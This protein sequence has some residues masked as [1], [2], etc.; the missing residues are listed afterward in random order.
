V[1]A[2]GSGVAPT[3]TLTL[4]VGSSQ[5]GNTGTLSSGSFTFTNAQLPASLNAAASAQTLVVTYSG[6]GN[7]N[8]TTL[9]LSLTVNKANPSGTL[10]SNGATPPT[11]TVA[12]SA[13]AGNVGIPGGTANFY[14]DGGLLNATPVTLTSGVA[15]Y[16][17]SLLSGTHT[18]TATYSGDTNFNA[19]ASP[20]NLTA[21][22]PAAATTT[23]VIASSTN[24]TV[25][26]TVTYTV[27]VTGGES[28]PQGT[29]Q[30]SDNGNAIC[31]GAPITVP[32][33]SQTC[34]VTYT[35]SGNYAAGTHTITAAYTSTDTTRW[36]NS[37][38]TSTPVTVTVA[39]RT[40][41][42]GT[43][44]SSQGASY[45][46]GTATIL[47]VTLT[48]GNPAPAYTGTVQFLDSGSAL[49]G[50]VTLTSTGTTTTATLSGVSL[51]VGSHS[52]TAQF[53]ADANYSASSASSALAIN[54]GKASSNPTTA[55]AS[56]TATYGGTLTTSAISVPAAGSGVAPTGTLTLSVGS[57]QIGNPGTLSSGSFTFTNAQLPASLNAAASAQ[58]LLV[59]YGGD[60]NYNSTTL[61]LSLTVNKANP[62]GTL[63]SN[64]ASPPTF[65]LALS[66]PGASVGIPSGTAN[67]YVDGTKQNATPVPVSA[68]GVA[69]YALASS[70]SGGS[71]TITATYS[72]DTNFNAPASPF[73]L[74]AALPAAATTTTV[75]ASTTDPAV[76]FRVTYTVSVTGG[77]SAP[78]GTVQVSDNGNAICVG[79]PLSVPSGSQTCTVTYDGS[80]NHTAGTHTITAA[81]TST[82]TTRWLNSD[83]TST[84]V[85]VTVAKINV[86]LGAIVSS[87]G[88][89]YASGTATNLTVTLTP[90]NPSP[91][92]T[93]T[94]QFLDGGSPLSGTVT[95]TSTGTTTTA[96]LSG[97]SL[98]VGSHSITAQFGADPNYNSSS[99]TALAITVTGVVLPCQY[100]LTPPSAS[101]PSGGGEGGFN[102]TTGSACSWTAVVS[103]PSWITIT[104]VSSGSGVQALTYTT[105]LNTTGSVRNGTITVN[106]IVYSIQQFSSACSFSINPSSLTVSPAGGSASLA[107]SASGPSCQWTASGLGATPASGTGSGEIVIAIPASTSAAQQTLTATIGGQT[108]TVTQAGTACTAALNSSGASFPAAG[109]TGSVNVTTPSAC[110]Y[111]TVLGPDWIS[112]TAGGSG[113]GSGTLAYSVAPNAVT[114]SRSGAL[115]IGGQT[116]QITQQAASCTV[117]VDT[118]TS[119]F[120]HEFG[121][122]GGTGNISI[123]T[124]GPNC[125]W[126]ATSP[127]AWATVA[128]ASGTGNGSVTVTVAANQATSA[129][130]T[131]LSIGGQTVNVYEEGTSCSYGLQSA[132]ASVPAS[133]GTS[134]VGVIA[135]TGCSWTASANASWLSIV[136]SGSAGTA[137]V[138][139]SAQANTTS[140]ARSGTLTIAGL[141]YTV[142]QAGAACVFNLSATGA[143]VPSG[144]ISNSF[145]VSTPTAGCLVA[146]VPDVNWITVTA[147]N[148]ASGTVAY[149][150]AANP[151]AGSRTG[152]IRVGNASFAISQQG[153]ACGFTLTSYSAAF[154]YLGGSGTITG[155]P[156]VAGCTPAVSAG[157]TQMIALGTLSGPV[158]QTFTLPF[159]VSAFSSNTPT[160]RT[161]SISF[162]GQSFLVKQSSY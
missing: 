45:A 46:Y 152:N 30:V 132:S 14:S 51:G 28:A 120:S 31:V 122:A 79:A 49:P 59:T 128:P 22:L 26:N 155:T 119:G 162:G 109:G 43:I 96:T 18:I 75:T 82:D 135:G 107:V 19:P 131:G 37:N 98:G 11:F 84:P 118:N 38:S 115:S 133:G 23:T 91:A 9:S 65:T 90:G 2:A 121:N 61:S 103:D 20:F 13:P 95:L 139:W 44:M 32:S 68:A 129:L 146:A 89:S 58:A 80:T 150:V 50:T 130:S 4:T 73:N 69:T 156:N 10:T 55:T 56:Y 53:G 161:A 113:V 83:S 97:V 66:A 157:N 57:S 147:V 106:G 64:G 145:T 142:N 78:Q 144:G 5:I 104:S 77:A 81:Y 101:A 93:G 36:L 158:N 99:S 21:A 159:T 94:V 153:A 88:A 114:L 35:G 29:V 71:H 76:G 136:S 137:N 134:V 6:D 154:N 40:V 15:S 111:A 92:Y 123:I 100:I 151:S 12:L 108:F 42:L 67:F 140:S 112:V 63:T 62:S 1:L 60:G 47:T 160:A 72:G 86:T 105:A 117:S 126:T 124:N 27:S 17:S 116:F 8:S 74:T 110:V 39:K 148:G 7:Y 127:A 85:T 138:Q 143:T 41:T 149:T 24:P 102:I 25:G 141:T 52:I 16:V 54:V 33:G 70:L 125:S 87:Q 34:T 3:G 48:P